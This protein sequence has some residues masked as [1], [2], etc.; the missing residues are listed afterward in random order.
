MLRKMLLIVVVLSFACT[1]AFAAGKLTVTQE[2]M[3]AYDYYGS[4]KAQIFAEVQNTGDKTVQFSAGIAEILDAD[5]NAIEGTDYVYCYPLNLAP[6]EKGYVFV[7][8]YPENV[9]AAQIVDHTL[10]VTSRSSTDGTSLLPGTATYEVVQDGYW[11]YHYMTAQITNDTK[12]TVFEPYCVYALK[13][14][15]GQLL[16]ADYNSAYSVGIPG[17]G[18]IFM[19]YSIP[20]DVLAYYDV[21]GVVPVTVEVIAFQNPY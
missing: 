10:N 19:R 13:D 7:T 9:T 12:D 20:D 15:D 2:H 1:S 6:G 16:Y 4:A 5:G 11:T 17:G 3:I 18:T 21:L 14:A 8:L